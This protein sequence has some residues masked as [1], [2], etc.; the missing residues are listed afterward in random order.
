MESIR[1]L[2]FLSG[3]LAAVLTGL[4]S[5]AA[6]VDSKAIYVRM[7]V[8]MFLFYILGMFVRNTVQS[9][10]KESE[11]R[12]K[13][14]AI[15]EERKLRQQKEEKIA[16]E[17]EAKKSGAKPAES[18]KKTEADD[19]RQSGFEPLTVSRVIKTKVKE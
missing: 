14:K 15:E 6:G 13:E 1:K 10:Q 9:I 18:E 8:M 2:P 12:K 17:L 4:T 19:S 16:Q 11:I 5:F 7:A 3:C